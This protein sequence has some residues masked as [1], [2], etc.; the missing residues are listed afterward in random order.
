[1]VT[2]IRVVD[3]SLNGVRADAEVE[4]D[5]EKDERS[6]RE[7]GVHG[8]SAEYN[9]G[10]IMRPNCEQLLQR[11]QTNGL[12]QVPMKGTG[13]PGSGGGAAGELRPFTLKI[14]KYS[15]HTRPTGP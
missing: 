14:V 13:S 3:I 9:I 7:L 8:N 10:T 11:T 12:F 6:N 2:C 4:A 1:M 5:K 15:T